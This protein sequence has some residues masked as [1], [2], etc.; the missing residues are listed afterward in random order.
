MRRDV[1]Y[2]DRNLIPGETLIYD[3]GCHW[4]VM[5]WPLLGGLILGFFGFGLFAGGWLATQ[6]RAS[7]QGAIVEGAIALA[8]AAALAF[9]W[10]SSRTQPRSLRMA[11]RDLQ[12]ASL[13]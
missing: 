7:Y 2:I 4:I 13:K 10:V 3:T 12:F 5:F 11:V 6:K 9:S 8:G 1:S